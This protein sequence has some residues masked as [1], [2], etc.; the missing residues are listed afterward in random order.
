MIDAKFWH[1]R[2][3]KKEIGFHE[4]KPN[5][6]LVKFLRRLSLRKNARVFVPLC[7]KTLDIGWL[8]SKGCRVAGAELSPI[9]IDEL[10]AQLRLKPI[11]TK[12]KTTELVRYSAPKIDIFCGDIFK[13]TRRTL[14]PVNAIYDRA[15][16]VALPEK[17]RNR[18]TAHLL[19]LTKKAPQLLVT[20]QYD[21]TLR[22][23]PPFSITNP[24]LTR[25][26]AKTYDLTLLSSAPL[27]GGLKG[28]VPATENLWL[29]I[30]NRPP[31]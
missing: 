15:A 26:Y 2:W 29:L 17:V 5:P 13:L 22:A 3:E 30:R 31:G 7:G 28:N 16:L 9:A 24:E 27:P 25:H 1:E 11:I 12:S 23:G 19:Q 21:Q 20:F 4:P 8:L 6:L 14:G 18:Y 10:F